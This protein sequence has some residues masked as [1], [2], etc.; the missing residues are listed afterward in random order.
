MRRSVKAF[1]LVE[2][3]LVSAIIA[4]VG[5]A[6]FQ[7]FTNGLKLWTR[8]QQLNH[9]AEIAMLFDKMGEDLRSAILITGI[10][11]KGTETDMIWPSV[12]MTKADL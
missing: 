7:A 11:F 5:V 4:G 8:T 6:V 10:N 12:V 2:V 1:T 3:L 9:Q